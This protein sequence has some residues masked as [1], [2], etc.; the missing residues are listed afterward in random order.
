VGTRAGE[1][2]V[3]VE[4]AGCCRA[5]QRGNDQ[6]HGSMHDDGRDWVVVR[7]GRCDADDVVEGRYAND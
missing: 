2:A 1:S 5:K 6:R 7:G 4:R 3:A